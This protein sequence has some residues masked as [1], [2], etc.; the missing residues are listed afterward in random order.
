MKLEILKDGVV[1]WTIQPTDHNLSPHD[2]VAVI[3]SVSMSPEG[4]DNLFFK[5]VNDSKT[6]KEAYE[7]AE[8]VHETMFQR[9]KYSDYDSFSVSKSRRLKK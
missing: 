1:K 3:S 8:K 4:F 5:F 6:H 7:R 9:R 2:I